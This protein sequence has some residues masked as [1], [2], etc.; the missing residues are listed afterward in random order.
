MEKYGTADDGEADRL[1]SALLSST[2]SG[3][4]GLLR[5][6]HALWLLAAESHLSVTTLSQAA[7]ALR[8]EALIATCNHVDEQTQRQQ[9]WLITQIKHRSAHTL[10][11]PS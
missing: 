7:L 1:P 4:F 8:D 3:A 2:R 9:A 11:V 6:L 10:V 5:D